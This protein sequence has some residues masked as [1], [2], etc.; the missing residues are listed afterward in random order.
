M[1]LLYDLQMQLG[2]GPIW[3]VRSQRYYWVDILNKRIYVD[4]DIFLEADETIG[5]ISLRKDGEL[6]FTKRFS[7]WTCDSDASNLNILSTL[8][9]E[10]AD[11]RFNDGKC[12]PQGRFLVGT[13]DMNEREANGSLYSFDGTSVTRLMDGVTI[14]N[15]MAWGPDHKTFY[16]ID[17]P[18]HEVKAYDYD[19]AAGAISNE[20][21]AIRVPEALG[22][23]DGMTSD[24]QGNLWIA[25]WGGAQITKW[26]PRDGQLLEQIKVPALNVSSCVFGGRNMNELCITSARVGLSES[27]LTK[28]PLNGGIFRH[29]TNVEGMPSFEF[30]D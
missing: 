20:R 4:G 19:L 2:E 7:I 9:E 15:G 27:D 23:P 28:Y 8:K 12:D 22:H 18:T 3:D 25:M 16:Y 26:D 5:C 30:A 13:M 1:Q 24:M 14:S 17:T 29:E 6:L 10:P 11:N 21:V